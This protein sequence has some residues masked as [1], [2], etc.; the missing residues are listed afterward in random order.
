MQLPEKYKEKFDVSSEGHCR[1]V[2]ISPFCIPTN[3]SFIIIGTAYTLA[4]TIQAVYTVSLFCPSLPYCFPL[5]F[6]A[7]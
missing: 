1:E 6:L 5:I 4:Q 3:E 2:R 7:V